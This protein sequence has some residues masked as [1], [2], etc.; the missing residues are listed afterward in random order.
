M[1]DLSVSVADQVN[2]GVAF[3]MLATVCRAKQLIIDARLTA[4]SM[5]NHHEEAN[6]TYLLTPNVQAKNFD[7]SNRVQSL[8]ITIN[9]NGDASNTSTGTT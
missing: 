2:Q 6:E 9:S 5:Q 4:Q 3:A 8:E 7:E 1:G